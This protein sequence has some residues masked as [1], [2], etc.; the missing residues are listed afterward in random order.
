M[1]DKK[2][3]VKFNGKRVYIEFH[4]WV[5]NKGFGNALVREKDLYVG[6]TDYQFA[7]IFDTPTLGRIFTLDNVTMVSTKDEFMYHEMMTHPAL[8]VHPRPRR[9]VV[10][11]GGDG[12]SVR[13]ILRHKSIEKVTL[14]EIDG[15]VVD[16]ARKFLPQTAKALNDKRCEV[17]ITDGIKY[18]TDCRDEIDLIVCD[19]TDPVGPGTVLFTPEFYKACFRA[20]RKDGIMTAQMGSPFVIG[21][22]V[23]DSLKKMRR[24]FPIARPYWAQIPSYADGFYCLAFLSKG[25]DP[26]KDFKREKYRKAN[27]PLKYY[28]DG[29]QTGAFL[30]P[31]YVNKLLR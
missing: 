22:H 7:Q 24:V 9:A 30:L 10:I 2:S 28:N 13:E 5:E 31:E 26:Q 4:D 1:T 17:L 20:L 14:A 23:K 11:G 29:L 18:I 8:F 21:P 3:V 16:L 19:S 12:G 27:L 6:R 25:L 15:K